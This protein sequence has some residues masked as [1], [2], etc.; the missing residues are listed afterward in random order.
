KVAGRPK[1]PSTRALALIRRRVQ[2]IERRMR[3][4]DRT[5][6]RV[7]GPPGEAAGR[8]PDPDATADRRVHRRWRK[9]RDPLHGIPRSVAPPRTIHV[10]RARAEHSVE[11]VRTGKIV[12][13]LRRDERVRS[14]CARY[15]SA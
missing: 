15:R 10:N 4:W 7:D 11:P 6:S 14:G 3:G 9:W 2:F 12:S 1:T 5:T 8:R 13:P